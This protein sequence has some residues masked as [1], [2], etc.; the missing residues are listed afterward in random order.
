MKICYISHVDI[1][2]PNGPGVNEREFLMTLKEESSIR[3][4][5]ASCIILTPTLKLDLTLPDAHFFEASLPITG[6]SSLNKLLANIRLLALIIK[7][8]L[9]NDYDL[10]ILRLSRTGILIPVILSLLG[11]PYSIKTLGNMQKYDRLTTRRKKTF[12][13]RVRLSLF[14]KILENS[15]SIDVCTPQLEKLYR[16]E[17]G[18]ENIEVVDNAV[19]TQRFH[20]LAKQECKK[21]CGLDEFDRIVGYCGGRPS[22]RGA[23]QLVEISPRLFAR[24]PHTGIV[25]IGEDEELDAL[26]K[27]AREFGLSERIRFTGTMD[28]AELNP[29]L[30]C[31]DVG[32]ALD[33]TQR[34]DLIGNSS[35]KIRQ[36]IACGVPVICARNTNEDLIREKLGMWVPSEDTDQLF[37][38]VCQWLDLSAEQRASFRE[39]AHAYAVENLSCKVAYEKRYRAWQ[40]GLHKEY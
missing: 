8:T 28:Y 9:K 24:Y 13:D 16:S 11:K 15:L 26:K 1:S 29:Y 12:P 25:I 36:Y 6:F 22:E 31:F 17:F 35:Q 21:T 14:D 2:L 10:F 3:G 4:D 39:K 27:K 38:A 7:L 23:R 37:Y 34:I 33:T 18:I 19:N 30:N 40:K 32:V 20:L 5:C